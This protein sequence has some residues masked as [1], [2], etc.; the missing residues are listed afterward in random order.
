MNE[1]Y[2]ALTKEH[3]IDIGEVAGLFVGSAASSDDPDPPTPKTK[4]KRGGGG[5]GGIEST[6]SEDSVTY[7]KLKVGAKLSKASKAAAVAI[8]E[9][10]VL[11][12][13]ASPVLPSCL[14]DK[15]TR[16]IVHVADIGMCMCV[17]VCMVYV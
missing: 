13:Q 3:Q 11:E 7:T 15:L 12:A 5:G 10:D 9:E 6:L 1:L 2:D 16:I 4:K 14:R 8:E 17:C